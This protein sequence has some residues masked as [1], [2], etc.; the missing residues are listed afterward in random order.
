M[1]WTVLGPHTTCDKP[2][3]VLAESSDLPMVA[4]KLGERRE[5]LKVCCRYELVY[6]ARL[7]MKS[8]G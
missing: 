3:L 6:R 2:E 7:Q 5:T 4:C 1:N 8:S